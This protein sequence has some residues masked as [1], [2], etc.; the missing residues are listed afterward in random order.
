MGIVYQAVQLSLG[1]PVALKVLPFAATLDSRRLQRFHNEARAAAFMHHP[2]IVPVYA[3]GEV[4]G[5]HYYAMQLIE[6]QNLADL[7]TEL[8]RAEPPRMS[9]HSG[10]RESKD[11]TGPEVTH[12]APAT[13]T[14]PRNS[15]A[16]QWQE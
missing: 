3:V 7:I 14:A 4:R 16:P 1:R 2:N 11:A 13:G 12:P 9:G 5:V 6:G 15:T 8:R 10:S